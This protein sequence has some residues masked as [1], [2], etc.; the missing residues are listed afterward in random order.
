VAPAQ[1]ARRGPD[2][3]GAAHLLGRHDF[4]TFRA[5]IC[6][7]KSPVK[8]LDRIEIE[9]VAVGLHGTATSRFHLAARSFLHNQVRSIVGTL[10]RVGAGRMAAGPRGR[11][12]GGVRPG[13]LRTRSAAGGAVPDG[14]RL[15]GGPLCRG[16][17]GR[18]RGEMS[19]APIVKE[20]VLVGGGHAH[21]LVLRRWGMRPV[22]GVRLTLVNPDPA[23][24]YTGMLPGH[25]AGHY[26]REEMEIDLVRLARFAGARL[27]L[28]R[29]VALD[30]GARQVTLGSGRRIGYDIVS[31]DV[32]ITSD[33]PDLPGFAEHGRPAKPFGR[34]VPAWE[35]V[36]A[37]AG[38]VSVAVLGGGI[39]GAELAM[40]ASHR[41]GRL[42]RPHRV[43]LIDRGEILGGLTPSSAAAPDGSPPG[44]GD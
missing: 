40:A 41:L 9:E 16:L 36:V 42:G 7:A 14:G 3:G 6:Q 5:A 1:Y 24:P 19:G 12:A 21:A 20:L 38:P 33:L 37:G 11:G 28:D 35:T 4:T 32:G 2:A 17:A 8:T 27:I 31:V 23:A 34:F 43:T 39:A 18:M 30:P 22:P 15:S 13:G 26:T 44:A 10:E 25:V 29:A